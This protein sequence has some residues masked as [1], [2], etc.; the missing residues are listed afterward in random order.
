SGDSGFAEAGLQRRN[1]R[2]R[3]TAEREVRR[4]GRARDI[5]I[6][7]GIDRDFHQTLAASAKVCGVAQDR[8][9]DE[10]AAAVVVSDREADF[11][12]RELAKTSCNRFFG[13][14]ASL[15]DGL[16]DARRV[17]ADVSVGG[18]EDEVA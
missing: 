12:I 7:G 13:G 10:L 17:E 3:G 16:I 1:V 4:S 5:D 8:V 2:G 15:G 11:V 18:R 6:A 9:D 14:R